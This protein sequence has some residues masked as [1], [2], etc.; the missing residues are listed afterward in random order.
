MHHDRL[1]LY[2]LTG[3]APPSS[4]TAE[5][6][7]QLLRQVSGRGRRHMRHVREIVAQAMSADARAI[8]MGDLTHIRDRSKRDLKCEPGC[9]VGHCVNCRTLRGGAEFGIATIFADRLSVPGRARNVANRIAGEA[10][11]YLRLRWSPGAQHRRR[12]VAYG[13]ARGLSRQR[14]MQTGLIGD[15]GHNAP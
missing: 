9:I 12:G 15:V 6:A 13:L 7:R 10:S 2:T 1:S 4:P 5:S 8:A 11:L 14:S 3:P